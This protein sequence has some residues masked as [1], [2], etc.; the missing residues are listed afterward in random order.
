MIDWLAQLRRG[1]A[2][3]VAGDGLVTVAA[4]RGS[5][6]REAGTRMIVSAGALHGT[7]GGGHLEFEAI[8]IAR[9]ALRRA[10]A[11]A[12]G[13]CAFRS[14]PGSGSAAAALRR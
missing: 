11:A 2:C 8:R 7:I 10:T 13:W 6:P 1:P 9:D 3:R 14:P 5:A 12:T 4:T